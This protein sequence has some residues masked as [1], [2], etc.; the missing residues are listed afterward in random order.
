MSLTIPR[1]DESHGTDSITEDDIVTLDASDINV[2]TEDVSKSLIGRI[3]ADRTFS[4]G[5]VESSFSAIWNYPEGLQIKS[6]GDNIYQ[7]S[8]GT[9]ITA[10]TFSVIPMWI[11]L[12]EMPDFCKTKEAATKIG[13]KLGPDNQSEQQKSEQS[14][15]NAAIFWDMKQGTVICYIQLSMT[16]SEVPL[17]WKE[18]LRADQLGWRVTAAKENSNPNSRFQH[19]SFNHANKKPTPVSLIKSFASLSCKEQDLNKANSTE[20]S[21]SSIPIILPPHDSQPIPQPS[22]V[23]RSTTNPTVKRKKRQKLKH[24]A[25]RG[26]TGIEMQNITGLKR[27]PEISDLETEIE[28]SADS[29]VIA[30]EGDK[31]AN[32]MKAPTGQ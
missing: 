6:L 2:P 14:Y 32:P 27:V 17:K 23:L 20:N 31:G 8:F 4:F 22:F 12:W 7:F 1:R 16:N 24:M 25:R 3:M 26:S 18:N 11:Q 15:E 10:S 28:D 21:V 9:A 30:N 19:S 29:R 5:L 13:T